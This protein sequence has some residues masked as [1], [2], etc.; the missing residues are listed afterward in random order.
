MF[1]SSHWISVSDWC[2]PLQSRAIL[3]WSIFTCKMM[4][5]SLL[6]TQRAQQA[7]RQAGQA[8]RQ[9]QSAAGMSQERSK[10][11]ISPQQEVKAA[12]AGKQGGRGDPSVV[13]HGKIDYQ[14]D[15]GLDMDRPVT[16]DLKNGQDEERGRGFLR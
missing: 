5:F 10:A 11:G 13:M 1:L 3:S 7:A 14:H 2:S 8:A 16:L 4:P 12:N 9:M 6:H 15:G